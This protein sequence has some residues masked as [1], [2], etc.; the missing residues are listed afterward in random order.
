MYDMVFS[1]PCRHISRLLL[2]HSPVYSP[3]LNLYPSK[4]TFR[5]RTSDVKAEI[6]PKTHIYVKMSKNYTNYSNLLIFFNVVMLAQITE[7]N[8]SCLVARKPPVLKNLMNHDH[9]GCHARFDIFRDFC[10]SGLHVF[11]KHLFS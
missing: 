4:T 9:P 7:K 8:S 2:S 3:S 6:N 5:T 1:C 10:L 11:S